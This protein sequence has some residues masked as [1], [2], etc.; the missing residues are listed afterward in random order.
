[1]PTFRL[2]PLISDTIIDM[3]MFFIL[4]KCRLSPSDYLLFFLQLSLG[5]LHN[6]VNSITHICLGDWCS[7]MLSNRFLCV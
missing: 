7:K 5:I 3:L 2:F 1:M 4:C 6:K